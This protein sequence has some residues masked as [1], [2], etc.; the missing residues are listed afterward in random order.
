MRWV[1]K[2][3]NK[4]IKKLGVRNIRLDPGTGEIVEECNGRNLNIE[5]N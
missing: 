2:V 4:C 1:G 5:E 3:D